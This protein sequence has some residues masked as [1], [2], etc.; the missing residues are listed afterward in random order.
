[1]KAVDTLLAQRIA[2]WVTSSLP[3][4]SSPSSTAATAERKPTV[5]AWTWGG[6]GPRGGGRTRAIIKDKQLH[7]AFQGSPTSTHCRDVVVAAG[8]ADG[9]MLTC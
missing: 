3:R 5:V 8:K 4:V 1:M 9:A 6:G 2:A 7:G